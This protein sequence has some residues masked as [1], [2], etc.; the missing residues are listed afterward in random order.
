[1]N[2]LAFENERGLRELQG[3]RGLGDE[4]VLEFNSGKYAYI[5]GNSDMAK[6]LG[7]GG[8]AP[9]VSAVF[10]VIRSAFGE[11]LPQSMQSLSAGGSSYKIQ[12]VTLSADQSHVILACMDAKGASR[13]S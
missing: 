11:T 2:R 9:D 3:S 13:G 1:M 8:F 7:A 5:P 12:K 6:L 4:F 10:I